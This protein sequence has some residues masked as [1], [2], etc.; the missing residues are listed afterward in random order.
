V[1]DDLVAFLRARL[2]EDEQVAQATT[3][4]PWWHEPRKQWLAPGA[5]E[6]Y[7]LAQGEE[8]VGYGQSPL[9]GCIAA[10]GPA[11]DQ[12]SMADARHIARHDPA[13]VLAEV[14]AKRDVI[15]LAERAHDYH[16]TF[17]SGFAAAMEDAL[18]KFALAYADHPDYRPEWAPGA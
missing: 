17:L 13:R 14:A 7:D 9:S 5:F 8:F 10:T 6:R 4:G 2:D 18:R 3:A 11:D 12:Q 15:R 1:T 16:A